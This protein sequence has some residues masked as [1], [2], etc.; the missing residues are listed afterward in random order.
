MEQRFFHKHRA[1]E[2][3]REFRV[4][5]SLRIAEEFAVEV[6]EFGIPVTF[7]PVTLIERIV[8]GPLL[9]PTER[10]RLLET[11]KSAGVGLQLG[12]STLLG[13]PRYV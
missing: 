10:Q 1:F 9:E 4:A 7:D 3:E 12:T 5:I 2:W 11:C 13:R 6:P 8:V